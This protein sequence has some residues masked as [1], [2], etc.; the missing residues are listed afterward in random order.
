MWWLENFVVHV[1]HIIFLLDSGFNPRRVWSTVNWPCVLLWV[2]IMLALK[3]KA[4]R[5][6]IFI[7]KKSDSEELAHFTWLLGLEKNL[8]FGIFIIENIT[9]WLKKKK[10]TTFCAWPQVPDFELFE[11]RDGVLSLLPS[12]PSKPHTN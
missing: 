12:C 7:K 1:A 4:S 11:N 2:L 8:T 5:V 3:G 9:C 6:I 10:N